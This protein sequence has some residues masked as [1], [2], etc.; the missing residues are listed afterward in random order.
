VGKVS[1][2]DLR[3]DIVARV[4]RE[5]GAKKQEAALSRKADDEL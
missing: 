1:K 3:A 2:K 5:T 4:A